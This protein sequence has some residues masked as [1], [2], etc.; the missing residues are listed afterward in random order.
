VADLPGA[1]LA[2]AGARPADRTPHDRRVI[3]EVRPGRDGVVA[4]ESAVGGP[5]DLGRA[6]RALDPPPWGDGFAAW[7]LDHTRSVVDDEG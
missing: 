5:A 4:T 6:E 3:E 7:L 2:A 1:V